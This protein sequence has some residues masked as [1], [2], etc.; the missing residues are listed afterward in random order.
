[1]GKAVLVNV[2]LFGIISVSFETLPS[3]EFAIFL[4]NFRTLAF[5]SCSS[6]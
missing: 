1:M 6:I 4:N 5:T 2:M 3:D